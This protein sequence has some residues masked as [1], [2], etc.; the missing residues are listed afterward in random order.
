MQLSPET[1]SIV[2]S[3][4]EELETER[5]S[6][7]VEHLECE[8]QKTSHSSQEV[9]MGC[10]EIALKVKYN[11]VFRRLLSTQKGQTG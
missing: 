7:D 9:T 10:R 5:R 3:G 11:L 8:A 6:R 4:R 2:K 1:E